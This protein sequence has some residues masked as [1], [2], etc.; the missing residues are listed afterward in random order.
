M[1][2]VKY[3]SKP[4]RKI[5]AHS[6]HITKNNVPFYWHGLTL[7]SASISNHMTSKVWDEFT[8]L[9]PN[10]NGATKSNDSYFWFYDDGNK[11]KYKY[12]HNHQK[13]NV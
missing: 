1:P 4:V 11:L 5:Y 13:R 10:F 8:Y 6:F 7:I 12:F 9:F 2:V 3:I